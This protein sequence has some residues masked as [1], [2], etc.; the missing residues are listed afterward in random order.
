MRDKLVIKGARENNLKD[1]DVKIPLGGLICITGVS[2]SGKSTLINQ[3]LLPAMKRKLYGS[4]VK[5]GEHKSI[6]GL[7]KI[8]KV[9]ENQVEHVKALDNFNATVAGKQEDM[10]ALQRTTIDL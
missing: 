6:T 1:I 5:A 2:G 3:T 10:R 7:Q 9:I 8:D 4:K